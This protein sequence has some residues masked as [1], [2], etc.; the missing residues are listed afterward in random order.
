MA[1]KKSTKGKRYSDEEKKR[2]V[3]FANQVNAEKGRGG[4]SAAGK[5]FGVSAVTLSAW[6][7]KAAPASVQTGDG[8]PR[9]K[10]LERLSALDREIAS[11]RKEL[12]K[13]EAEFDKLK[14]RL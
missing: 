11:K 12:A 8:G 6:L 9:I 4:A 7:S 3:E 14:A 1:A 13:L 2:I 5:K 10:T